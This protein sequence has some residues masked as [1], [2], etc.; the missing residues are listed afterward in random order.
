MCIKVCL[1]DNEVKE[2]SEKLIGLLVDCEI[3]AYYLHEGSEH[4]GEVT[5]VTVF[6]RDPHPYSLE[7]R[8]N[9]KL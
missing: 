3:K 2:I 5:S 4:K 7:F 1:H 8:R 6:L 9:A